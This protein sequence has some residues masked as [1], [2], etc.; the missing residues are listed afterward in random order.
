MSPAGQIADDA[1]LCKCQTGWSGENCAIDTDECLTAGCQNSASCVSSN[2]SDPENLIAPGEFECICLAGYNGIQCEVDVNECASGPCEN[3]GECSESS[4]DASVPLN[5]WKCTCAAGFDGLDCG[6][7]VDE[8]ASQ[9]CLNGGVCDQ[10]TPNMFVCECTASDEFFAAHFE[11][12]LCETELPVNMMWFALGVL[13]GILLLIA[14]IMLSLFKYHKGHLVVFTIET[15]DREDRDQRGGTIHLEMR[16]KDYNNMYEVV[17]Q[18]ER[19]E[20]IRKREQ[21]LFLTSRLKRESDG[22]ERGDEGSCLNTNPG[23]PSLA[24]IGIVNGS[25][26]KLLQVWSLNCREEGTE[27]QTGLFV[28]PCVER[29]WRVEV[30]FPS[31]KT[32]SLARSE[33]DQPFW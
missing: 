7:D 26:V 18:V 4:S 8:C 19:R 6:I 13:S 15:L 16:M 25:V 14:C 20:G 33:M 29:H 31:S 22:T 9:P 2:A 32:L 5:A 23:G 27:G 3:R 10:P 1:Y 17:Q 28:L 21:R 24:E 11:G 30:R 12:E